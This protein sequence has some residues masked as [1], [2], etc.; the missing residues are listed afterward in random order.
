M[1]RLSRWIQLSRFTCPPKKGWQI[2]ATALTRWQ[3]PRVES[4]II[5]PC[6]KKLPPE[7]TEK[8]ALQPQDI[9]PNKRNTVGYKKWYLQTV[10]QRKKPQYLRNDPIKASQNKGNN[11]TPENPPSKPNS[12]VLSI[13][14]RQPFFGFGPCC[15]IVASPFSPT[16]SPPSRRRFSTSRQ[17]A[18]LMRRSHFIRFSLRARIH[19]PT[20][21]RS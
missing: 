1:N 10:E 5:T 2:I 21:P 4:H 13:Y 14:M 17:N 11:K 7:Q 3:L 15:N 16:C 18:T 6:T 19:Q 20:G 9:D 12:P 8:R